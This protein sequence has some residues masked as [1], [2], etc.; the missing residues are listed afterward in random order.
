MKSKKVLLIIIT[1]AVLLVVA[2][3]IMFLV[4]QKT[5]VEMKTVTRE[6]E[7]EAMQISSQAT[8]IAVRQYSYARLLTDEIA[9]LDPAKT[10]K[11]ELDKKIEKAVE[12]WKLASEV[13]ATAQD[14]T[15]RSAS[16]VKEGSVKQTI[17]HQ[18]APSAIDLP[19]LSATAQ[20]A[21]PARTATDPQTWAENLTK[22]YDVLRGAK[23]YQQL[24][25]QLG[26]DAK[27]AYEQMRLAQ[28]I[29]HNQ[30][31]LDEATAEIDALTRSINIVKTYKTAS[32]VGLLAVS[33]V[34]TGGGSVTLLE[35]AGFVASGVDAAIEVTDTGS[36]IILGEGNKVAA[37]FEKLK[38]KTA[39]V[40]SL[41]GLANLNADSAKDIVDGVIYIS[42]SIAD[43]IYEDRVLGL[44]IEQKNDGKTT[45]GGQVVEMPN[46][47]PEAR[48]A[49]VKALGLAVPEAPKTLLDIANKMLGGSTNPN[50]ISAKMGDLAKQLANLEKSLGIT[51]ID[52]KDFSI[53]GR[54]SSVATGNNDDE[55]GT[56]IVT[57]KVMDNMARYTFVDSED[58]EEDMWVVDYDKSTQTIH[59]D[60]GYMVFTVKFTKTDGQIK[61]IGSMT[62]ELWG[63]PIEAQIVLTK[64]GD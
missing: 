50:V 21:S 10:N 11:Q 9:A 18:Y 25:D 36:T 49:A 29:I 56:G 48:A 55:I 12:D 15:K 43:F 41:I 1:V 13:S 3:A 62:G 64:L 40:T 37:G 42:D 61:G 17:S 16:I 26:I 53:A 5:G 46:A 30:A 39:P 27:T 24:A 23:R 4:N 35:G 31:E 2:G 59:Y 57:I 45:I 34:A 38:D 54:Y 52:S 33:A 58:G 22:Q 60:A 19:S 28:Q 20:A 8:A 47:S 7:P 32:K 6:K 63:E 14:I 44:K 51:N